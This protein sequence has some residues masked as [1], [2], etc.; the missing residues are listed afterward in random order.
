[1][2]KEIR[3]EDQAPVSVRLLV[4]YALDSDRKILAGHVLVGSAE[5]VDGLVASGIADPNPDAVDYAT[6]NGAQIAKI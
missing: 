2:T 4:D 5:Q 3:N 6:K 1:M